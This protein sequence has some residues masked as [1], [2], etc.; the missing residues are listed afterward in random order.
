MISS[1]AYLTRDD[2]R[3]LRERSDF[4]GACL[5]VHAW[6]VILGA[7]VLF[8]AYPNPLTFLLAVMIIGTRQLGLA[9]L[10]HDAAHGL[11]FRSR[12]LN[13]GV[14]NWLCSYPVMADVRLYRP[15]HLKH[16]RHTQT[17]DDPDLPLSAPFPITRSSFRRKT[18]RD[19]TGQTFVRQYGALFAP[20]KDGGRGTDRKQFFG[21]L[22]GPIVAN[23]VLLAAA[24]F[25]GHWYLYP[26]LWLLPAATWRMWVTR[27]RNIAEH[28]VLEDN[29]DPLKYAR[30]TLAGP[31]ERAFIAPY[32][33]N[34]HLEHHLYMWIPCYNLPKAHKLLR[35]KGLKPRMEIRWGYL[36]V[37]RMAVSSRKVAAT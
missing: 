32:W 10:M 3:R 21:A 2:L 37:L 20:P 1:T 9:V 17:P 26:L 22:A 25:V 34:Y 23:L 16:H 5:V 24:I 28:A 35:A 19:L 30:T 27:I 31:L 36:E 8:A 18:V 4:R 14:A 11:L 12:R 33:V 6:G 13:D 29:T 15:Y 7:M